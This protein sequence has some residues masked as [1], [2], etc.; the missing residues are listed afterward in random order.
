MAVIEPARQL[1]FDESRFEPA[2]FLRLAELLQARPAEHS[3]KA[4]A[5]ALSAAGDLA[6]RR[7]DLDGAE[8]HLEAARA[9]SV[10]IGASLGEANALKTLG[11]LAL[12]R[13]DLDGAEKHLEAARAIYVRTGA[14]LGEANALLALGQL[15]LR[16]HDLNGAEKHLEAARAT[17]ARIGGTLGEAN[18]LSFLRNL[19]LR[20]YDLDGAEKHLEAVRAIYVRIGGSLGEANA[21]SSLGELALRRDDLKGAETHFKAARE[22]YVRIGGSLGEPNT[23]Y[24]TDYIEALALTRKDTSRAE[25]MFGQALKKYRAIDDAWG[26]AHSGLR[27]AQIFALRGDS[28]NLAE[29]AAKILAHE[30]R[31]ESQR[32]GPGWRAFCAALTETDPAKRETLMGRGSKSL[33][34]HRRIGARAGLSRFQ[35]RVE[36]LSIAALKG[37]RVPGSRPSRTMKVIHS[38][39]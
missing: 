22:I 26:I 3:A 13:D 33:D 11:Q 29:T 17:Y 23:D 19:A 6:L 10:R 27:L 7:D 9:I 15:A 8:K 36:A 1:A 2:A 12:R 16:R 20:R 38:G 21:L 37:V 5:A 39:T 24:I 25:A 4:A 18:A 35:D 14:S 28:S 31:D 34:R 32:A 30:T